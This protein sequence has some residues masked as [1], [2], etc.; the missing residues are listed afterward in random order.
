MDCKWKA[1]E[2]VIRIFYNIFSIAGSM[3]T[4]VNKE[5]SSKRVEGGSPQDWALWD[6]EK[7]IRHRN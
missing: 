5:A 3:E 2:N 7:N 4:E 6:L 1:T